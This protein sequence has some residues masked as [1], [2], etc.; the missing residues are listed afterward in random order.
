MS[1]HNG[2]VDHHIFVVGI[3]RQQLENALENTALGPSAKTL[4]RALP[5]TEAYR[6]IAPWNTGSEP[7]QNGL[8]E[9]PVIWCRASY[10]ALTAGQ[11]I[12]DPIPLV[13][14]SSKALHRSALLKPTSQESDNR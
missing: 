4:M 7:I 13:I 11:N 8:D 9:Q 12:L 2:G 14:A 1:A 6:Q 10:V 5:I 3:A